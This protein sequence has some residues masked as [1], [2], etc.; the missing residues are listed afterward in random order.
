[1]QL[2]QAKKDKTARAYG[3]QHLF[4]NGLVHAPIYPESGDHPVWAATIIDQFSSFPKT[5]FKDLVDSG[6]HALQH[7]RDVGILVRREEH[8]DGY[9][10]SMALPRRAKP[11]YPV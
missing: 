6:T 3:V 2:I 9:E 7:L 1:M 4:S 8:D 11:L 10:R 5:R